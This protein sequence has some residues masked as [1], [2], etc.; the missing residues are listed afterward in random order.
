[1]YLA[2]HRELLASRRMRVVFDALV[3]AL[4]RP[5]MDVLSS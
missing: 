2:A 5:P 1:M 3:A 4:A